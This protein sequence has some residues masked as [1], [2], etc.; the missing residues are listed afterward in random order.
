[1]SLT[2]N[3]SFD[4]SVT[5]QN[6]TLK[7]EIEAAAAQ[8]VT[9]L[10]ADFTNPVSFTI[11]VG[12]GELDNGQSIKTGFIASSIRGGPAD[13]DE[14]LGTAVLAAYDATGN[15]VESTFFNDDAPTPSDFTET[16]ATALGIYDDLLANGT[17]VGGYVGLSSSY[18]WTWGSTGTAVAAF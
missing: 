6:A 4:S 2:I 1:M 9:N 3:L 7:G 5:T 8:A 17:T 11:D 12:W 14:A 10:E 13:V 15:T 16:E 18:G